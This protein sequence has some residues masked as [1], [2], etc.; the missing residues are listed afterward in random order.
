MFHVKHDTM[1]KGSCELVV[2]VIKRHHVAIDKVIKLL[3]NR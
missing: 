1:F 2:L 3:Y